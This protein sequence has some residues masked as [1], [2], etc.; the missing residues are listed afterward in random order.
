[1]EDTFKWHLEAQK[2]W[3][4]RASFWNANS[5]EMWE[6]GS[7]KAIVPFY[8]R[9]NPKGTSIIDIGCGD[10]YGSFKLMKA[11]YK[12]TGVDLS[13]EMIRICRERV[14]EK[15]TD[16]TFY[17]ADMLELPFSTGSFDSLIAI[18]ALEWSEVPVEGLKEMMRV[19]KDGGTLCIGIL[20]PTAKPRVNSYRRV[21]GEP[22]IC[23]TMMPWELKQLANELGLEVID[24]EG[25]YK[26]GVDKRLLEQLSTDLR[27]SLTFMWLYMFKKS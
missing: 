1:M 6:E 9:N 3:D 5:K 7:R 27:Q 12:V 26:R 15:M 11:G 2:K 23:N 24:S 19:V 4:E 18:N 20:G 16:L 17:Q 22:V 10:G 14:S 25:I 8:E 21:Y 13:E